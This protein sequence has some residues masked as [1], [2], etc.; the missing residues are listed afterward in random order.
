MRP[1]FPS[2]D[3]RPTLSITNTPTHTSMAQLSIP[4]SSRT[5]V[6]KG[7]NRRLR[8]TGMI[9]AV[10]YGGAEGSRP[11]AV[12][13]R[14]VTDIVRSPRGVNTI[15]SL[16]VDGEESEEQVMI[17]DYQLHP[18]DHSVLHAD[19]MRVD[20]DRASDWHVPVHLEGESVGVKRGGHLDFIT[21]SLTVSCLPHDIPESLP[22]SVAAL[23]YGDS[24]RA[25]D[26]ALPEQL[27]LAT[28]RDVVI[29]H[30]SPPKGSA[31]DEQ[32]D[33]IEE[34]EAEE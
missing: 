5:A 20:P 32:E 17:H 19:L 29:V 15:F 6:G 13:P 7:P 3:L 21:R 12:S 33:E 34:E 23:D 31:E 22:L 28:D 4:A 16:K 10:V 30:V 18:L 2:P 11:L 26:I 9:P 24:V 1:L 14:H 25:A 27:T 8:A